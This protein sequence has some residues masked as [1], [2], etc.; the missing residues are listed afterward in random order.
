[1]KTLSTFSILGVLAVATSSFA[2]ADTVTVNADDVI[3]AAGSQ[4]GLIATMTGP[5]EVPL[6]ILLAPGTTSFTFSAT[7]SISIDGGLHSGGPDGST[8]R[9]ATSSNTGFGSISGITAPGAGYLVGVFIGPGGPSGPAPTALDFLTTS[10]LSLSPSL[11][12]TFF[13]GDGL[14]GTGSG[15]TQTFNVPT[16]ATELFLGISDA[17]GFNGAPSEYDDNTGSFSVTDVATVAQTGTT[18]T[19]NGVVPEPSSLVLFGS[20]ALGVLGMIRR[21]LI[22]R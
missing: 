21:R 20:G 15:A 22:S 12:Q 2:R 4:S 14:T 9:V 16:G 10:F 17:G 11:D 1:M 7:G 8:A 18:G 19:G 6:G 3:Y 5:G 13:I